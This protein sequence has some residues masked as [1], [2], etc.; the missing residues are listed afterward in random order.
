MPRTGSRILTARAVAAAAL[1]VGTLS[2]AACSDGTG[3]R[4]EGAATLVAG[5]TTQHRATPEPSAGRSADAGRTVT[6][7]AAT[8]KVTVTKVTRPLNHLLITATNTGSKPCY[9][10]NAPYLR[11]DDAQ[12]SAAVDRDSVPQAVVTLEP[13]RSAY[14]GVRTSAADGSGTHGRTAHRLR[15]HF[16]NRAMDGSVGA[17]ADLKLPA[18]GVYVDSSV[19]TTYWQATREDALSW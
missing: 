19:T 4:D 6:C 9:A 13:G 17:P 8:T 7:T 16:A 1:A 14:A 18:G 5:A 12:A 3:T 10:Y 11:F 15:V 2:L